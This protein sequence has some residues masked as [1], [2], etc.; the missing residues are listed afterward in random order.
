MKW[1]S[2]EDKLPEGL[3]EV[4]VWDDVGRDYYLADWDGKSWR[5][6]TECQTLDDVTHWTPLPDKPI[7]FYAGQ[8]AL[9]NTKKT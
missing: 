1:I 2:I 3:V 7:C 8:K 6:T 9:K 4:L 5:E